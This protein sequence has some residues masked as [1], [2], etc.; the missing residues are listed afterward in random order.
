MDVLDGNFALGC[1]PGTDYPYIPTFQCMLERTDAVTKKI[2]EPITFVLAY[3]TVFI[4][5]FHEFSQKP[6][7]CSAEPWL[8]NTGV[9]ISCFSVLSNS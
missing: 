1:G 5:L 4:H 9:K 6:Y 3:K 8:G 7:R 2:L